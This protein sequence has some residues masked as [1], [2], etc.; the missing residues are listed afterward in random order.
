MTGTTDLRQYDGQSG[1][2]WMTK[3]DWLSRIKLIKKVHRPTSLQNQLITSI[4]LGTAA[5][6]IPFNIF[7][8]LRDRDYAI[9][10]SHERL[11]AEGK[12]VALDLTR[13]QQSIRNLL[14]VLAYIPSIRELD[15]RGSQMIFDRI[16]VVFPVRSIRLWSR[17][18]DLVAT[19]SGIKTP[20]T[21]SHILEK[22]YF[23]KSING[24]ASWAVV[25]DC[26]TGSACFV[27]SIPVYGVGDNTFMTSSAKSVG[28][29]SSVIQLKDTGMDSGMELEVARLRDSRVGD[30]ENKKARTKAGFI[31]LQNN[32]FTGIEVLMV[33]KDGH[34]IF[35]LSQ[36]NDSISTLKVTQVINGPWGPIVRAGQAATRNGQAT[37]IKASGHWF[38]TY[39]QKLD[40]DWSIVA[41]SDKDSA[42]Q[43]VYQ[44]V[45]ESAIRQLLVII[46]ITIVVIVS[47]RKAAQPIQVAASAV[48]E[49]RVGNFDSE[50]INNRNDQIGMLYDDINQTGKQLRSLLDTKLAHAV[51]DKQIQIAADIQQ[52]FIIQALPSTHAV[53]L[54]AVFD[55]AYEIGADWYDAINIEDLTYVIIADVCDKGIPS[56][57]FMSV[58]Q[59]LLHYAIL[60]ES[61]C[62]ER[63]DEGEILERSLTQVNDYMS[64]RHGQ[65]SMFAT[66]FVGAYNNRLK[67]LC[68]VCA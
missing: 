8:L 62:D 34:T 10:L 7:T 17:D 65:C 31:S 52:E 14:S 26:L 5:I 16:P 27:N 59:S 13:W 33:H 1:G 64:K 35:P 23:Q 48:R 4:W 25:G 50:I 60:E 63:S 36:T 57:L 32:I 20:V 41:I 51:T 42:L 18:G 58:F 54:A 44:E 55:P 46:M 12:A 22:S 30:S 6:L 24:K 40:S 19:T 9:Q 3:W 11:V 47:C 68:Y 15:E 56:A 28:V 53:E 49:F 45:F 66:I 61:K 38:L 39:S 43:Q 21:R 29:L 37:Q 2:N 67:R